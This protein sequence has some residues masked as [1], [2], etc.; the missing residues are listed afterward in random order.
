MSPKAK[1]DTAKATAAKA[2]GP[3][4][5]QAEGRCMKCREQVEFEIAGHD[6][7]ANGMVVAVGN[8]PTCDTKVQRILG[9]A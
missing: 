3:I 7:W 9:K 5:E 1:A 2:K 6:Q 8:C 4:G